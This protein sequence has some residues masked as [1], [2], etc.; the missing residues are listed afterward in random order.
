MCEWLLTHSFGTKFLLD[1]FSFSSSTLSRSV[2]QIEIRSKKQVDLAIFLN[3]KYVFFIENCPNQFQILVFELFQIAF[4]FALIDCV[5]WRYGNEKLA[6]N[7]ALNFV[8]PLKVVHQ[9][10]GI[11]QRKWKELQQMKSNKVWKNHLQFFKYFVC[12]EMNNIIISWKHS[13]NGKKWFKTNDFLLFLPYSR[14]IEYV[15]VNS[16]M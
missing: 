9:G 8:D 15:Y 12:Q 2:W 6:S 4:L 16:M 3:N 13:F 10:G 5:K 1:F 7:Y 14:L 11:P